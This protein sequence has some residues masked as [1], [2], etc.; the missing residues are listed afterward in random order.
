[1]VVRQGV[2]VLYSAG[3]AESGKNLDI[4][5]ADNSLQPLISD[6]LPTRE[7]PYKRQ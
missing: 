3:M 7:V 6:I 5:S 1:M 2:G 4:C